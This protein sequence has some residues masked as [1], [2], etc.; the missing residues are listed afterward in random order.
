VVGTGVVAH[1]F[2]EPPLLLE[3]IVT[4]LLELANGVGGEKIPSETRRLVSSKA[5]AFA[6]F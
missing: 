2:D 1:G 6:P 4:V 3:P 5:T